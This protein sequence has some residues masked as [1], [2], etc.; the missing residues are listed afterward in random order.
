MAEI[1][2]LLMSYL[3]AGDYSSLYITTFNVYYP[4]GFI[5]WA[6]GFLIFGLVHL[7]TDNLSYSGAVGTVYFTLI[8]A[9]GLLYSG[10]S[11]MAMRYFALFLA[12]ITAYNI[13]INLKSQDT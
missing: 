1:T 8:S 5:L 11:L 6:L 10:S 12:L 7:K 13:Y 9:S 2:N 3:T 4:F